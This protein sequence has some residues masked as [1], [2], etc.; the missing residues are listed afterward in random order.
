MSKAITLYDFEVSYP[1]HPE[2]PTVTVSSIG[3]DSA[4][5]TAAKDRWGL[6]TKEWGQIAGDL[7]VQKLGVTIK[8]RCRV[9]GAEVSSA[10]LCLDCA[11]AD[12]AYRRRLAEVKRPDRRAGAREGRY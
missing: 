6:T 12:A 10:G 7:K 11:K 2:Y 3:P 4:G 9:C 8:H 5:L 1:G